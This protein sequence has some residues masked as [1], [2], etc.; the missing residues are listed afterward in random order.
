MLIFEGSTWMDWNRVPSL[1]SDFSSEYVFQVLNRRTDAFSSSSSF[2]FFFFF[3]FAFLSKMLFGVK[4][5]AVLQ[6]FTRE[7]NTC[8]ALQ[9]VQG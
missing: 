2:F 8:I 1:L 5:S 9:A 7:L 3:F 4:E 6:T